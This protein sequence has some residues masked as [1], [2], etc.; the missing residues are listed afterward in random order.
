MEFIQKNFKKAREFDARELTIRKVN[1]K[2]NGKSVHQYDE[3]ASL[4]FLGGKFL[5]Y[6]VLKSMCSGLSSFIW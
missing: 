3:Q 2:R 1:P 5:L 6:S 4:T